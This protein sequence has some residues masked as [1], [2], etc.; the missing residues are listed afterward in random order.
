[1][2]GVGT[3]GKTPGASQ[4]RK[5]VGVLSTVLD[6]AA[7]SNRIAANPASGVKPPRLT[8]K[9]HVDPDHV[10]VNALATAVAGAKLADTGFTVHG[11]RHT[12][13]SLAIAAGADVQV[14]PTVLGLKTAR[15]TPDTYGHLFPE[16]LDEVAGGLGNGRAAA[17]RKEKKKPTGTAANKAK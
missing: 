2:N 14:V 11:L 12:A 13:A 10:Q 15:M 9:E 1:M 5:I 3:G 6:A 4:V 16:R 17:L 8:D 7:T